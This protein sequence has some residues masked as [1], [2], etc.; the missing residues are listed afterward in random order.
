VW[1][2]LEDRSQVLWVGTYGGG[3]SR[4][5]LAAKPF[6]HVR[7]EPGN[8][9]SLSHDIVWSI[10]EDRDGIL[11]IGTDLGGLNRWDRRTNTW[12]NWRHDPDD[13]ASLSHDTVR[14]ITPDRDG[15]LW[16]GTNGGGLN[17]FDPATGRCRRFR[18]DPNDPTSLSHDQ[19]RA[20]Y[21]DRAGTVWVATY[22]GG[23]DRFD[24]ESGRFTHFRNDPADPTTLGSDYVRA[25]YEDAAGRLWV[26][27]HGGGLG[28]LDRATGRFTNYRAEPGNP[29][30][31]SGD[32][33][34]S[35]HEDR[36]GALWLA[37][38]GSG[39]NRL[40]PA[41]GRVTRYTA[42]D[43]L[44]SDSAYGMLEDARG[45]LWISSTAGLT[46]FDPRAG[47]FR[48]YDARDGLQSQEFNGG[49]FF[50]S[51]SGEMF[52]GGINGFSSF[53]PD[54]IGSNQQPPPVVLSDLLLFNRS[55]RPGEQRRGRVPLAR[56]IEYADTV[57]LPWR[58]DVVTL[59][60]AALHFTA[61]DK[62][63]YAFRLE[64]FSDAWIETPADR[65]FATFTG[66]APGRYVFRV[67]A[68]NADG[69]WN[70]QGA[71]VTLVVLPPFWATWWFR[72]GG[73][74]LL[75]TAA[76]LALRRRLQVVRLQAELK[77]AHD[78][79]MAVM[80]N[81]DPEVPGFDVSGTCAPASEVS[82]DFFDYFPLDGDGQPLGI[83]VGDV[84]GKAMRAA[85]NALLTSGMVSVQAE[86]AGSLAQ[87]MTKVNRALHRKA[88]RHTF[89]ALCLAALDHRR[90]E[91]TF[92]NAGLCPPLLRRNDE[93][94]EIDSVGPSL[95]LGALAETTYDSR[96]VA[97]ASGDVVVL[98]TDGLPEAVAADGRQYGYERL[99]SRL[100]ALDP[101]RLSA[102]GIRDAL[103]ADVTRFAAGS[104]RH[105]DVAVVVVKAL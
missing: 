13:P 36:A 14:V 101:L 9:N 52:F 85:M 79:Q 35:I 69:V 103:L 91:L 40:D 94:N 104:N 25:V 24:R 18:H 73:L 70:E 105:D 31:L 48:N 7:N 87:A 3:L 64:G 88:L 89:T 59:E 53:F 4:L 47:T 75:A 41:T 37:T 29:S 96:T 39:I 92:V 42:A 44:P 95:P 65:R 28:L 83:A 77:A 49:S 67:K 97:L 98:Y 93:V 62:N 33:V 82:G 71:A 21:Q 51:P 17:R 5:D 10:Y 6:R 38:Y 76:A 80:P 54:Q 68:A 8:P 26:G 58:D 50:A 102:A 74:L 90:R 46:R 32:F 30:S 2:L 27:T 86:S 22:G 55:L 11:W 45:D 43:G 72:A 23:L 84:S 78:V 99:R 15:T 19:I 16:L 60:F 81:A 63:R 12:R 61:P 1:S 20:V 66:L 34:L 100:A 56:P 57:V